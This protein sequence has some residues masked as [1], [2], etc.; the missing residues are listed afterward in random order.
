MTEKQLTLVSKPCLLENWSPG[1]L[2]GA[3]R[4]FSR[5]ELTVSNWGHKGASLGR[6]QCNFQRILVHAHEIKVKPG[7]FWVLPDD[8]SQKHSCQHDAPACYLT[9][10]LY[11]YDVNN[12]LFFKHSSALGTLLYSQKWLSSSLQ[13]VTFWI[14]LLPWGP[15]LSC[16][17]Q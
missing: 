9:L 6:N 15:C 13:S 4:T 10:R 16:S 2:L 1:A 14:E 11:N 7:C 8:H 3:D 17:L 12:L 5:W